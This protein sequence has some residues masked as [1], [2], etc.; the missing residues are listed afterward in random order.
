MFISSRAQLKS[1][2]E[3]RCHRVNIAHLVSFLDM[4]IH[5][6]EEKRLLLEV[7][8][9]SILRVWV[10]CLHV[11]LPLMHAWCPTQDWKRVSD[12]IDLGL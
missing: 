11:C 12:H 6:M 5:F 4:E 10:S 7:Y 8:Y 9:F 2:C 1:S 3:V